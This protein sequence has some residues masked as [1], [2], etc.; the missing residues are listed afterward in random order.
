[1]AMTGGKDYLVKSEVTNY[2]NGSDT[3]K[4]YIRVKEESQSVAN[5]QTTL[6]VGMWITSNY[7][8]G[9]WSDSSSGS[10]LGTATSG[11]NC[12][13]F[14]GTVSYGSGVRW[15]AEN[16]EFIVTHNSDG[17]KTVRI[18]WKLNINSP[19]GQYVYP[20]GYIDVPLTTIA[21]ASQ[22][23]CI[24]WPT[25]T[26][27]VGDIGDTITIH[28]NRAS[29]S[30]THTV[31]WQWYSRPEQNT[32]E[33]VIARNVTDNCQFTIPMKFCE[34]I[35]NETTGWGA[36]CVDTYNNG[37]LVGSKSVIFKANV[38]NNQDTKPSISMT[39][40]LNNGSLGSAFNGLYIMGKSRVNVTLSGQGKYNADIAGYSTVISGKT[41]NNAS[42]T[43]DAI[44]TQGNQNIVGTVTDSRKITNSAVKSISVIPY[45][46]PLVFPI[47]GEDAIMCYRS[48]GNG[49]RSS[50]STSVWVKAKRNYHIVTSGG[51]QKNF[52][53]LQYRRKAE[54]GSWS[55]WTD[56]ISKSSLDTDEYNALIP[57]EVFNVNKSYT[58]EIRAIDDIGEYTAKRFDIPTQSVALH[59]GKGGDIVSVGNYCDY[60]KP[61]SF[62]CNWDAYLEKELYIKG[63]SINPNS[64][65][66][67][68]TSA[69]AVYNK[70]VEVCRVQIDE[71]GTYLLLG[72]IYS[73][74]ADTS[75]YVNAFFASDNNNNFVFARESRST[76]ASG[77]G[78]VALGLINIPKKSS[79]VY[80]R[81]YGYKKATYTLYGCMVAIRLN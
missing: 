32:G 4:L 53:A 39:V 80:L 46:K 48:D 17:T 43:S 81:S 21:R 74:V 49:V 40:T 75:S 23:S 37:N 47:S 5:N 14:D 44:Q 15:L 67:A 25:T 57:N 12:K 6:K 16:K 42:F 11:D 26:E 9:T 45:S 68:V 77:G 8:I 71:P 50:N 56:L 60:S 79:Y 31:Y 27:N 13:Y 33:N 38:P 34:N 24:T 41:Y 18:Y 10:Y 59:L 69:K 22:P 70:N 78:V 20:N 73:S 35:P 58:V 2:G 61:E 76:M 36:I 19:W 29:N 65:H 7:E 1:M 66:T 55:S 63:Q 62:Q 3:I 64:F 30:F 54:D 51:T 28:M 72:H 52:C